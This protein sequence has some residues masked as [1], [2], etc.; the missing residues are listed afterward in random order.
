LWSIF[1]TKTQSRLI[2]VVVCGTQNTSQLVTPY[3]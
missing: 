2:Q 3:W 1:W